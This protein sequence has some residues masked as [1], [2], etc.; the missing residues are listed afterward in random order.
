VVYSTVQVKC[1]EEL[2]ATVSDG[3]VNLQ[4]LEKGD[5]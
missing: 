1:G 5:E 2:T 3:E 4:V